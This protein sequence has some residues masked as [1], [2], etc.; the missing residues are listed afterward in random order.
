MKQLM[1]TGVEDALGLETGSLKK[2][3]YTRVQ[4]WYEVQKL[5]CYDY[6]GIS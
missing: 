2:P 4:L 1:L 5:Q 3:I 6:D